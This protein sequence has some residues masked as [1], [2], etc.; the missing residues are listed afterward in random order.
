MKMVTV[1][2]GMDYLDNFIVSCCLDENV[3]VENA[4]HHISDTMGFMSIKEENKYADRLGS[5]E[6]LAQ[7]VGAQ[8]QFTGNEFAG[9]DDHE[10]RDRQILE[11]LS[12]QIRELQQ[13][14]TELS[15]TIAECEI[16]M[17]SF[18]HFL[19]MDIPLNDIIECEY[20][21]FRFG[22]LPKQSLEKLDLIK[23]NEYLMFFPCSYSGEDAWGVYFAPLQHK[24]EIDRIFASMYF[25]RLIIPNSYE[26]PQ[27]AYEAYQL[28]IKACKEQ[29]EQVNAR[30][31]DIWEQE[32]HNCNRMYSRLVCGNAVHEVRS[33]VAVYKNSSFCFIGWVPETDFKRFAQKAK[34]THGVDWESD[35]AEELDDSY[36]PPTKL[37]NNRLFRPFESFVE[38]YGVPNY[39]EFDPTTVFGILYTVIFGIM[40]ADVGQGFVVAV[41]GFLLGKKKNSDLGRIFARC[42]VSSMAFGVLFGSVFGFENALDWLYRLFGMAGKPISILDSALG[43]ILMGIYMGVGLIYFFMCLN[44]YK[45]IRQ[46]QF[47]RAVFSESGLAGMITYTGGVVLI[48]QFLNKQLMLLPTKAC[49]ALLVVG[50][51]MLFCKEWCISKFTHEQMEFDGPGDYII[52]NLVEL[53]EYVISYFTN[54]LSF[55]RVGSFVMVHAVMMHVVFT[56]APQK[57]IVGFIIVV[58]FGNILVASLE[59]LLTYI[60]VLRLGFYEMFSRFYEGDGEAFHAIHLS[61]KLRA[62][63]TSVKDTQKV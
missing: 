15:N 38:M 7:S 2:G 22:H 45:C 41:G 31:K 12:T 48:A 20:I 36:V 35:D 16:A 33:N 17:E 27:K 52:T 56:L 61:D 18:S 58:V 54:T 28:K 21:K 59:C 11:K 39:R 60:Q 8:L 44:I 25:E 47:A 3:Q 53:L 26:T 13:Q 32:E 4:M 24:E 9:D 42:G 14:K 63:R 19:D 10:E 62:G 5:L 46:K 49:I 55:L 37:K 57:S 34:A 6:D 40:F 23:G 50:L 30:F 1:G 51:V 29:I 43:V